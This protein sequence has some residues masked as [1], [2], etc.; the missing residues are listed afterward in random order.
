MNDQVA[1]NTG[2]EDK[3]A[4]KNKN[5]Q[6]HLVTFSD[7]SQASTINTWMASLC[8][9]LCQNREPVVIKVED[10]KFGAN[11]VE[12]K[13]LRETPEQALGADAPITVADI[14]F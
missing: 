9:Q 13:R 1:G 6:R 8:E 10:S 4:T 12:V 2:N 5:V 14:P 11:L 7:A 3:T